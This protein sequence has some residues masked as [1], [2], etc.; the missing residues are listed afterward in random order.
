MTTDHFVYGGIDGLVTASTLLA[1]SAIVGIASRDLLVIGL[2]T[3]VADSLSM[4]FAAGE[5]ENEDTGDPVS[6]AL[7]T[8]AAFVLLGAVPV[9]T[10]YVADSAVAALFAS[11]AT[12]V[13]LS[14]LRNNNTTHALRTCIRRL[15]VGALVVTVSVVVANTLH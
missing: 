12:L 7:I 3:L 10:R 2:S 1:S 6:A 4:A 13:A 14:L 8:A 15:L 11:A 5:S 9:I